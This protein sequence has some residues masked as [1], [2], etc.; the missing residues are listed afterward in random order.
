LRAVAEVR[1]KDF[2]ALMA[3][4]FGCCQACAFGN[5]SAS[6][7]SNVAASVTQDHRLPSP[8]R[9]NRYEED[10]QPMINAGKICL[11]KS[12]VCADAWLVVQSFSSRSDAAYEDHDFCSSASLLQAKVNFRPFAE[13]S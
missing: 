6:F 9:K 3:F 10:G 5:R 1:F 4:G 13:Q 2:S 7:V 11:A 12:A 8:H